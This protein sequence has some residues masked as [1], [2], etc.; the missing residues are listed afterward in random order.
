MA[1]KGREGSSPSPGTRINESKVVVRRLHVTPAT[2]CKWAKELIQETLNSPERAVIANP[3]AGSWTVLVNGFT[4]QQHGQAVGHDHKDLF[5]L[6]ARAD[7]QPLQ[8]T[9]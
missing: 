3:V 2:I 4:I 5:T 8:V 1:R 7:G 9:R 6:T